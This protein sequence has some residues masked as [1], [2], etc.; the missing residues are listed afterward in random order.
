MS[1]KVLLTTTKRNEHMLYEQVI[2]NNPSLQPYEY[3]STEIAEDGKHWLLHLKSSRG[4][5]DVTCP[6]CNSPVHICGNYSMRLRDMPIHP[7]TKQDIEIAYHRYRCQS[8]ERTFSEE[9]PFKHSETRITER[10]ASWISAFL[11]F[12]IPISTVQKIT[13]VHWDTIKRIHK[14]LMDEAIASRQKE[15]RK[16]GYKPKHLAVDEFAIH[17]G[18]RYATCVM[19]LDTGDVLWA[20]KGRTKADF[21]IFFQEMD[22]DYLSE[23]EA[24]AMDMNASYNALVNEHMP[25]AEIVYDR[26]HMQ[27]QFGKDVLGAVRLEEARKHN[28]L[29]KQLKEDGCP[30]AAIKEEKKLYSEV[31][32]AR[33]IL[34]AGEDSLSDKDASALEKILDDHA[35][36]ALC[37]AMKEEM[38]R[39]FDLRDEDEARKGWTLWFEGAKA[40]GIPAL[41]RFAERKEKRLD[42]LIA[43][44]SHPISTG[45]L[46]G[47]NNRI[48]VAKRIAYGYRDE[49]YFFSLIQF[50]SIPSVR[51]QSPKKT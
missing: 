6:F 7:G 14:D 48:K 16:E 40:S 4:T 10:A 41:V 36:L 38:A 8:C 51:F 23:V 11:R 27:A 22:M 39:L 49:D 3:V 26:Y 30:K 50:I 2:A 37:H 24:V 9:I 35:D 33:W 28:A 31:K 44:A 1:S 20:G 19:D 46:E 32:R 17:K 25:W 42:G 21:S 45:K 12:N 5:E 34:L 47:F 29:A 15:L 43:H 13:G 18:H